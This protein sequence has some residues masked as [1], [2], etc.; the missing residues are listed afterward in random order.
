MD[1]DADVTMA[2]TIR[3]GGVVLTALDGSTVIETPIL[4]N[5]LQHIAIEQSRP[6]IPLILG[7]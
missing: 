7:R 1:K 2:Q 6:G 4:R 5:K 3:N